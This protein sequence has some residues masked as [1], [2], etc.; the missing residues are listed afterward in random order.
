MSELSRFEQIKD[1]PV[2]SVSFASFLCSQ[3]CK[4]TILIKSEQCII[5]PN[6]NSPLWHQDPIRFS[7]FVR[8]ICKFSFTPTVGLR[9]KKCPIYRMTTSNTLHQIFQRSRRSSTSLHGWNNNFICPIHRNFQNLVIIC[10]EILY[11]ARIT[12]SSAQ[13]NHSKHGYQ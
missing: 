9:A 12:L 8:T 3:R 7:N 6:I 10:L 5:L 1:S 2:L 4:L 11:M 13:S